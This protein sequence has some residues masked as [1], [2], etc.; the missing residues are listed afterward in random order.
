MPYGLAYVIG[1]VCEWVCRVLP[2]LGD[3]P[4]TR[5]LVSVSGKHH[6]FD[7]SKAKRDFGFHNAVSMEE[8]KQRFASY[9]KG[10]EQ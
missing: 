4:I 10:I 2:F 7:V 9:F 8:A 5:A 6:Y 1:L 3:P